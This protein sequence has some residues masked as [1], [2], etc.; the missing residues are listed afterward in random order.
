MTH[1]NH[2]A[3]MVTLHCWGFNLKFPKLWPIV[4]L[5]TLKS[6][7]KPNSFKN[8]SS[9][10]LK[11]LDQNCNHQQGFIKQKLVALY[12]GGFK[13]KFPKHCYCCD[14]YY[15]WNG[16]YW[17]LAQYWVRQLC[18]HSSPIVKLLFHTI[19]DLLH[20]IF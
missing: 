15:R 10:T 8:Q 1:S 13:L 18:V 20:G 11:L 6:T 5:V 17:R 16:G 19:G 3:T 7:W 14:H 9:D 2:S 12:H 4:L